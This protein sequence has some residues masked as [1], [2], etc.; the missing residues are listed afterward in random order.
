[1][2]AEMST[3]R[4]KQLTD[5]GFTVAESRIALEAA[6]GDVTRAAELLVARRNQQQAAAGGVFAAR[7]NQILSE[8]RPWNEFFE[9]FLWP[10]HLAERVQ[11]NLLYYRANYILICGGGTLVGVLLQPSLL[12]I[13][14]I[15]GGI[16]YGAIEWGDRRPVPGLNQPLALDQRLSAAA[17]ASAGVVHSSGCFGQAC[18]IAVVCGGIVL[19]HAAFRARSLAARWSFFKDSVERTD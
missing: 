3:A 19:G 13:A 1:M 8:Q 7:I 17:L 2:G 12:V 14:C 11:T 10:E 16:F 18:R 4:M 6:G 5:M 9:R 15:V